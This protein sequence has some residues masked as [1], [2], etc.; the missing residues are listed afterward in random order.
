MERLNMTEKITLLAVGDIFLQTNAIEDFPFRFVEDILKSGD[1]VFGNLET[2]LS[3]DGI[4]KEKAYLSRTYPKAAKHLKRSSFNVLNLANNHTMDYRMQGFKSTIETLYEHGFTTDNIIGINF[5]SN[6]V[7]FE[8]LSVLNCRGIKVGFLGYTN[9]ADKHLCLIDEKA[10]LKDIDSARLKAD[11]IVVSLHWGEEYAHYP[12]PAQQRL[13][14]KIVDSGASIILGHHP[15]VIQA[16]EKYKHGMILYSLGNFNF[17]W[18]KRFPYVRIGVIA[19][20]SL[21][22][23]GIEKFELIPIEQNQYYQPVLMPFEESKKVNDFLQEISSHVRQ[24]I[25]SKFWYSMVSESYFANHVPSWIKRIRKYG[26]VH[27]IKAA[28]W[29]VNPYTLKMY[30]GW[31]YR[32]VLGNKNVRRKFVI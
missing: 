29:L 28:K 20:F 31:M 32:H 3:V 1:I 4:P 14:R 21:S 27:A 8:N 11:I 12:K 23:K 15:H 24:E 7:K 10:I 30:L 25:S 22:K 13:A 2:V 9:G 26:I 6:G 19:I 5:Y 18:S 16:F 17:V